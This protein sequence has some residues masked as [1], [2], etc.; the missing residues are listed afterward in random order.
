MFW[1]LIFF[2]FFWPKRPLEAKRPKRAQNGR[3]ALM[4]T[5]ILTPHL[6]HIF[7]AK[8]AETYLGSV[9]V[10]SFALKLCVFT[11][12]CSPPELQCNKH[13]INYEEFGTCSPR[14]QDAPRYAAVKLCVF[15]KFCSPPGLQVNKHIVK[16]EGL[17]TWW[18]RCPKMR[19]FKTTCFYEVLLASG[20]E[21]QQKLR[22]TLKIWHMFA[23]I[24][25]IPKIGRFKTTCFYEVLLASGVAVQ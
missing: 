20:A 2:T 16:R 8:T 15:T 1:H 7:L 25:R 17:G 14:L 13:L 4:K 24:T 19:C 23:N 6:F 10:G 22:K 11:R 9:G 18:L 12:F 5:H 3:F 21:A